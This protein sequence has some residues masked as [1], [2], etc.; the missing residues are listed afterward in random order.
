MLIS[1]TVKTCLTDNQPYN[2]CQLKEIASGIRGKIRKINQREGKT[3]DKFLGL[4]DKIVERIKYVGSGLDWEEFEKDPILQKLRDMPCLSQQASQ[5]TDHCTILS[6][7][8]I[9]NLLIPWKTI[10]CK[11]LAGQLREK[12]RRFTCIG[13]YTS[14]SILWIQVGNGTQT[15]RWHRTQSIWNLRVYIRNTAAETFLV[16]K[17]SRLKIFLTLDQYKIKMFS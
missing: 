5:V 4:I 10:E 7:K 16:T 8:V 13:I 9:G 3:P 11:F 12:K 17:V 15:R 6:V 2:D 14:C 1:F